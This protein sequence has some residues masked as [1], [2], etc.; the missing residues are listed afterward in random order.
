MAVDC[1]IASMSGADLNLNLEVVPYDNNFA[2]GFNFASTTCNTTTPTAPTDMNLDLVPIADLDF[3][4]ILEPK[5]QHGS[6]CP[7]PKP[8]PKAKSVSR[9]K[10]K[11]SKKAKGGAGKSAS[12][13]AGKAK[14]AAKLRHPKRTKAVVKKF[15]K[16]TRDPKA[17]SPKIQSPEVTPTLTFGESHRLSR[18]F[19]WPHRLMNCVLPQCH[20]K[21]PVHVRLHTEFSGAGTAEVSMQGIASASN[22][23]VTFDPISAADWDA[24]SQKALLNNVANNHQTHVFSDIGDIMSPE[25]KDQVDLLVPVK[26]LISKADILRAV[27]NPEYM[28]RMHG[29]VPTQCE[30]EDHCDVEN[31]FKKGKK[32][33]RKVVDFGGVLKAKFVGNALKDYILVKEAP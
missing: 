3:S 2:Q 14:A 15:R 8:K 20:L 21:K 7:A 10:S 5:A 6:A 22:G 24:T 13:L 33:P 17:S 30:G 12:R 32:I 18:A 19:L 1:R 9:S 26:V 23:M 27:G 11:L 28:G 16:R 29:F 4:S 31:L 25:M